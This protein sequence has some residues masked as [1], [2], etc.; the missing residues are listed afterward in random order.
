M[1]WRKPI[2]YLL[3][4]ISGSKIP[5][6]LKEIEKVEKFSE[7]QKKEYQIK[8]LKKLLIHAYK[9]VPYYGKVLKEAGVISNNEVNLDNFNKIPILTK[10]II[11][12]EGKKLYSKDY[13]KRGFYK[14]TSGGSTGEPV[15]FLQDKYYSDWNIA[16]KIYYKTFA[17][18]EIG[19]R[20]LRLW[21]TEKDL[22][23][24][25]EDVKVKFRNWLYNRKEFNSFRMS[26]KEM[27]KFAKEWNDFKPK[28]VEAYAQS[29]YEFSKFIE[30]N[31]IKIYK[32]SGILTSAGTLYPEMKE[33]IENVFKTKVFNRYG[34]RE[35]GDV[36]CSCDKNESLHVSIHNQLLEI[37]KIKENDKFGK[38]I[39]TN[40]N[41]FSMPFIRYDI[42]DIA[43]CFL[44]EKC[45]CGRSFDLLEKIEGREMSIFKTKEGKLIPGEFFIH[46]IGVVFNEGFISK[47]Q[48]I[49]EDY[50]KI[51]IKAVLKNKKEFDNKKIEIENSIK[52]VMENNCQIKWKIVKEIKP[53]KNGKYLYTI[54]K[55]K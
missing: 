18:Q 21:G 13:K 54:S 51:K 19:E 10:D 4:Y 9:N 50:D 29:I 40:L 34:S 1:N 53:M 28:W 30:E 17:N 22:L 15:E 2:I 45:S 33:K 12:K 47:F 6:N 41:N 52:K 38:V 26:E 44:K 42:G 35:I 25:E 32:P 49:Q 24:G 46:F 8:K 43:T 36:A 11:R 23:E 14:N 20:E 31:N 7:Q 55:V 3:L 39:I 5:K 48:I 16:N 37:K 27:K